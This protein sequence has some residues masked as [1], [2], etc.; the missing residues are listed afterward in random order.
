LTAELASDFFIMGGMFY[1]LNGGRT[2]FERYAIAALM[3]FTLTA[4]E[5]STNKVLNKLIAYTINSGALTTYS[6]ISSRLHCVSYQTAQCFYRL[7]PR[8]RK[9]AVIVLSK[10]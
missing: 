5:H 6:P 2:D 8:D 1:Y 9:S 7:Y 10:R 3:M 4:G